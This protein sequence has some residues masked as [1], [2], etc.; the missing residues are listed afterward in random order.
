[1]MQRLYN[2][3]WLIAIAALLFFFLMYVGWG[4]FDIISVPAGP[5]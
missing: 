3:I 5:R 2:R 4:L 1:M